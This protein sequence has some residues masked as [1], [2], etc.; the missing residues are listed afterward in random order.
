MPISEAAKNEFLRLLT[1]EDDRI[2]E[3]VGDAQ[4]YLSSISYRD[5]LSK[6]LGI[7][8]PEVFDVLQDLAIDPG[9]GIETV[10]AYLA[11]TYL[12]LPGW[13]A[14]GL[15]NDTEE[16]EALV[17]HF[18][19]GNAS[20]ARLLVRKLIPDVAPGNTMEDVVTDKF[21]YSKLDVDGSL[22]R[23]RLNSTVT[24][25]EHD[26]S[27]RTAE[28]VRV[29]YVRGG[30]AY[31]IQARRCVL[32]CDNA[33]IPYLC[34]ELPKP[35]KEA[36][37]HQV[38]QPIL[39]TSVALRNW[40]AW[41]RMGI[42]GVLSPGSYHIGAQLDYP[43]SLGNYSYSG[44]PDE[45]VVVSMYRYPHSN[46]QGLSP[47]EQYRQA[48]HELLSTSFETI[49]RNVRVQ[50]AS[51]LGEGGFDPATDI[52]AITVN[53]WAHGYSYDASSHALFD[54]LYEDDRDE[55]WPHMRARKPLGRIA[56]ANSDAAASAMLEAAV[57]QAHRAISELP[58]S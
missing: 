1:V 41:K 26:G 49:E 13:K 55:R 2:P 22:A 3:T 5:Y 21:D 12:G 8:E 14:A 36:L 45:P 19:D 57:E 48:R 47:R 20:I 15:P 51:M 16:Y 6:H 37:A 34:P 29:S 4:K 54:K 40:Q 11:V 52:E 27:L 53:R 10:D 38:R 35:Q 58:G 9:V 46:N 39:M 25:V 33:I 42:G 7:T 17:H 30:Q 44:G 18:P 24:R 28:R 32:A 43:V 50:L 23:L 56:I 31:E